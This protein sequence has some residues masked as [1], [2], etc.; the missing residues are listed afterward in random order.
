[1]QD[2]EGPRSGIYVYT[3]PVIPSIGDSVIVTGEVS[4]FQW[5]D[6]TPEK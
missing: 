3:S 2:G 6:P 4:E 5:Q 1:M